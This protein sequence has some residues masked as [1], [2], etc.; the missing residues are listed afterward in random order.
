METR[1]RL[2][3]TVRRQPQPEPPHL[4]DMGQSEYSEEELYPYATATFPLRGTPPPPAPSSPSSQQGQKGFSAIV[5]QAPS[6]HDVDGPNLYLATP[7]QVDRSN[8]PHRGNS[9]EGSETDDYGMSIH[10]TD[11]TRA[12]HWKTHHPRSNRAGRNIRFP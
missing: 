6:L 4:H 5:Y 8:Q 12:S 2:Y 3:S 7:R 1:E 10:S 9:L 11:E